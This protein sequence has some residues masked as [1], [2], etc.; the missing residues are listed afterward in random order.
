M[1]NVCTPC[2]V[3]ES[4]SVGR[5]L[6]CGDCVGR[7]DPPS[8]LCDAC[9]DKVFA[10]SVGI[11]APNAPAPFRC[12]ICHASYAAK[13]REFVVGEYEN[14][15]D[16][17][18]VH[19]DIFMAR[20]WAAELRRAPPSDL[21]TAL[22]RVKKHLPPLNM[23]G[24]EDVLGHGGEAPSDGTPLLLMTAQFPGAGTRA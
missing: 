7:R 5:W 14:R 2:Q 20:H 17:A 6:V 21:R 9:A 15:R 22:V 23:S 24:I 10:S 13:R 3:Q 1:S 8:A 4:A 11:W 18:S 12:N 19:R 16:P